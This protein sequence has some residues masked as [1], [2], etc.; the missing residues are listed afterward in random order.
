LIEGVMLSVDIEASMDLI[1]D[2]EETL[3][4]TSLKG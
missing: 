3:E 2:F 4:A 1:E